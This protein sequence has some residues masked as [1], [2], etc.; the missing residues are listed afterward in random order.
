MSISEP[1][2][3][4]EMK[5]FR[6][7]HSIVRV[8]HV[9]ARF[10]ADVLSKDIIAMKI[11]IFKSGI[12]KFSFVILAGLTMAACDASEETNVEDLLSR[13]DKLRKEGNL[14]ASIIDLK[15]VLQKS[16]KMGDARLMLGRIYIDIGDSESA[17]KELTVAQ[18]LGANEREINFLLGRARLLR[19]DYENLLAEYKVEK[20]FSAVRSSQY[21]L[22]RGLAMHSLGRFAEAEDN[23]KA[24]NAAYIK[25]INEERP[26][27]KVT[28]LP[29]FVDAIIGLTNVALDQRKWSSAE[30]LLAR[31]TA[32][33]PDKAEVLG[34]KGELAFA[35]E[36]YAESEMA[37]KGAFAKKP[38]SLRL[39]I[40]LAR[41]QVTLEKYDEAIVNLEAV[42]K[43]FPNH[44]LT[45]YY[46]SLAASQS[47]D[48]ES[49][50][51]YS[52]KILKIRPNYVQA[53]LVAGIANFAL[54]NFEQA[55]L[56]LGRYL[57]TS[58]SNSDAQRLH[59]ITKLQLSEPS[60]ALDILMPLA[61]KKS[62]D[63]ALLSLI[64]TAAAKSG[65]LIL[66]KDFY[67]KAVDVDP[68]NANAKYRLAMAKLSTGETSEGL[69]ELEKAAKGSPGFIRN[70]Y[71]L[72]TH[73]LQEK[74]YEDA[75]KTARKLR[76]A[77]PDSINPLIGEGIALTGL[78]DWANALKAY[79]KALEIEPTHIGA[80][81]GVF[82]VHFNNKAYEKARA[83]YDRILEARPKHTTTL[84][85]LIALEQYL[86]N[87][88]RVPDL[89]TRAIESDPTAV[90]PRLLAAQEALS[91]GRPQRALANL[92]AIAEK[93]SE[94]P[95]VLQLI[96]RAQ[97]AARKPGE[98]ARALE[99]LVRIQPNSAAAHYL[100]AQSYA[101]LGNRQRM[102]EALQ[103]TLE[104]DPKLL[105]AGIANV[106]GLA[107]DGKLELA[108]TQLATLKTT[109]PDNVDVLVLE[110]WLLRRTGKPG[111][112][113]AV[114]DK[115]QAKLDNETVAIDRSTA[116]WEAD[117][118]DDAATEL[119]R[120]VAKNPGKFRAQHE[121]ANMLI[122]LDRRKEA[123]ETLTS[124]SKKYPENWLYF[125]NLADLL[126]TDDADAALPYAERAYELAPQ[127]PPVLMT[128][129]NV[130][131]DKKSDADRAVRLLRPLAK[132]FPDNASANLLLARAMVLNKNWDKAAPILESL[133]A[134]AKNPDVRQKAA[135]LL[136]EGRQ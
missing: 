55:N 98:A 58:P 72:L 31:A 61:K 112:A 76:E 116:L 11:N 32:L 21:H 59:A 50:K 74:A 104:L 106:R 132:R 97:I 5:N 113:V 57:Q 38:N 68:D 88:K 29:E 24:A 25:D 40:G 107:V 26:H 62:D 84:L 23:F 128:L 4:A 130:L 27:L 82:E 16:P 114:L 90:T 28:E 66:A 105:V 129:A 48:Y 64:A 9:T 121:L 60:E 134:N 13:A 52:D 89:L 47:Q 70:Q 110:A 125:V 80:A 86:G 8:L 118:R 12:L 10:Y 17:I 133:S 53:H 85:R 43:Y 20:D 30:S 22:L 108:K 6:E 73:Y 41:A 1:K 42:L 126:R 37:F 101:L 3:S 100:L 81:Y 135:E 77:L 87:T 67:A 109:F 102:Q 51:L 65:D 96:G 18:E 56:H 131:V 14:R 75:L 7:I 19:G 111:D 115:A 120:W 92:Q 117:R 91:Q 63:G 103:K 39:Q 94:D 78:G 36:N 49:A 124:L 93:N 33:S 71:T 44:I 69:L 2:I 99:K 95:R 136:A 34:A 35:R 54:R 83:V 46:R 122:I 79:E 45:N 127:M 15:T 119:Y 123:R